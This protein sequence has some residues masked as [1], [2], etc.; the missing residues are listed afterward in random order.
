MIVK[1]QQRGVTL[2]E[3]ML[4]VGLFSVITSIV[5]SSM[6]YQQQALLNQLDYSEAQQNGR[7]ALPY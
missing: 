6:I 4:A 1:K 7:A 2:I 3:L 5:F